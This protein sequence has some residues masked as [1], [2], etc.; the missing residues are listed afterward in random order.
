[1]K[2]LSIFFALLLVASVYSKDCEHAKD[3]N[4]DEPRCVEGTCKECFTSNDCSIDKYC[5]KVKGVYECQKYSDDEK[6]GEFCQS[7]DCDDAATSVV[8]G[9]CDPD[10]GT[11]SWTGV[12]YKFKCYPCQVNDGKFH[13]ADR[14]IV[15]SHDEAM[16]KPSSASGMMGS[17]TKF[18]YGN[19][20]PKFALQDASA[21]GLIFF[22]LLAFFFLVIQCVTWLRL[23]KK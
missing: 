23:S 20:T 13:P 9:K 8:C 15:D 4:E 7:D 17:V 18:Q 1:M 21:I 2:Y 6:L 3:C 12:C 5:N 22:G 11:H 16:C 10:G 14:D 19:G